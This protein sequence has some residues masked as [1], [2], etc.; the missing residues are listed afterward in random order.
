MTLEQLIQLF[1]GDIVALLVKLFLLV[2]IF[3]YGI[4][5]AVVL[6]QIQIMNKVVTEISFSPVLTMIALIHFATVVVL[7]VLTIVL[8]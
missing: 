8:I 4:F 1:Q 7:F 5:A 6:R 2:L 3:L